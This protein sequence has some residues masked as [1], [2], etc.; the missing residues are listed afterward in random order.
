MNLCIEVEPQYC[1]HGTCKLKPLFNSSDSL[2]G[3]WCRN[4]KKDHVGMVRIYVNNECNDSNCLILRRFG[5]LNGKK[6]FDSIHKQKTHR[7]LRCIP[8]I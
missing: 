2:F 7:E 8:K 1:F 3:K 6:E 5:F 4:H